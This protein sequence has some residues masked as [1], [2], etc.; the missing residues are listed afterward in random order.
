[1]QLERS[2]V[3]LLTAISRIQAAATASCK[4]RTHLT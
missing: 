4:L 3:Q 2:T 1:M